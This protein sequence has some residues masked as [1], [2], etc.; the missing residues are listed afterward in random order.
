MFHQKLANY[1]GQY[2]KVYFYDRN[3]NLYG[4][5]D[6][7]QVKGFDLDLI[8]LK[9]ISLGNPSIPEWS[10]LYL[11]LSD[12]Q[13]LLSTIIEKP[14]WIISK[15]KNIPLLISDITN[16]S[17][18]VIKFLVTDTYCD[19][20]IEGL[21]ESDFMILDNTHGTISFDLFTEVGNGYYQIDGDNNYTSGVINIDTFDYNA[22]QAYNF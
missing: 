15:V 8:D 18:D 7:T 12:A 19:V 4:V 14:D 13:E 16:P 10:E 22:S 1:S 3:N 5:V 6:S 17:S 21:L 9:K 2:L 11:E 20:P